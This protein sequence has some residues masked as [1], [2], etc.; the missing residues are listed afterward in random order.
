MALQALEIIKSVTG[1]KKIDFFF[2]SLKIPSMYLP[3]IP[4]LTSN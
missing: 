2:F 1:H 3:K 4:S